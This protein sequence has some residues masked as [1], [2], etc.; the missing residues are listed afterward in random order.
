[1]RIEHIGPDHPYYIDHKGI[2]HNQCS[3]QYTQAIVWDDEG[4]IR[5]HFCG[6]FAKMDAGKFVREN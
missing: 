2:R 4:L 3:H 6:P 5:A 1:M